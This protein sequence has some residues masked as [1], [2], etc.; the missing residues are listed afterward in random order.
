MK[1]YYFCSWCDKYVRDVY[2]QENYLHHY[3][4]GHLVRERPLEQVKEIMPEISKAFAAS[5]KKMSD[6]R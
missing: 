4:C 1:E 6:G 2:L 5:R 3:K